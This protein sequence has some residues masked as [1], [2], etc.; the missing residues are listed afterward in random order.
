MNERADRPGEPLMLLSIKAIPKSFNRISM[1]IEKLRE[2]VF[3]KF[4]IIII[5]RYEFYLKLLFQRFQYL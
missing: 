2:I 5:I 1:K 4:H 3:N